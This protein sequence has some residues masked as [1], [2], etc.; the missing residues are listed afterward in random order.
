MLVLNQLSKSFGS[1]NAVRSLSLT[2]EPG[3]LFGFLGPNG[4]GKTTTLNMVSGLLKPDSGT[5]LIDGIDNQADP[6]KAKSMMGTIPDTPYIYEKLTGFEYLE[7]IGNL[8]GLE[9]AD[10][11]K[12]LHSYQDLFDFGTWIH[13]PMESYSHGMRQKIVFTGALIH[14]PKLLVVDEPMVGLDPGSIRTVKHLLQEK[15]REGMTIL[16]STHTLEIAEEICTRVGIIH[17]GKLIRTGTLDEL[18]Q[19]AR[20]EKSL[21]DI[22]FTLVNEAHDPA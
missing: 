16:M 21:E 15:C 5:I 11:L 10:L 22:F 20:T 19:E 18:R 7:F 1:V 17:Q 2:L 4:A 8:Y 3:E 12:E 14:R 6:V 9:A 13:D